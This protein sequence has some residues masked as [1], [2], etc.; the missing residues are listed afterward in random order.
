MTSQYEKLDAFCNFLDTEQSVVSMKKYI[1]IMVLL[2]NEFSV[3]MTF[4]K[5]IPSKKKFKNY[6]N[7]II[8]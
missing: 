1:S 4:N 2:N 5:T 3:T 6:R 7:D 8:T